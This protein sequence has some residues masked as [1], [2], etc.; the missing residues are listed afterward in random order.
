MSDDRVTP[1]GRRALSPAELGLEM[2]RALSQDGDFCFIVDGTDYCVVEQHALAL[3]LNGAGQPEG[4]IVFDFEVPSG[5]IPGL[6]SLQRMIDAY[7]EP[8]M[9]Y[10]YNEQLACYARGAIAEPVERLKKTKQNGRS[11]DYLKH[12]PTK[13][14]RRRALR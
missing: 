7:K 14:N 3:L 8:G 1:T 13:R 5:M 6:D 9:L 10:G 4:A 11:A 12:D 2:H